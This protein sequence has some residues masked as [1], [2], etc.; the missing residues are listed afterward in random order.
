MSQITEKVKAYLSAYDEIEQEM[1]ELTEEQ[2]RWKAAPGSWSVT[3]VLTHLADHSIVVSFRIRE[4]LSGSETRLPAFNQDAWVSGQL[5]NEGDAQDILAAARAFVYYNSLL[6]KRLPETEWV[7]TAINFKGE[8][9][10][11]SA[12]ITAFVAHVNGHLGQIRRIKAVE[13]AA[14]NIIQE[15]R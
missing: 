11:L 12:I 14:R 9:V 3:E 15:G 2:L 1:K 13:S 6:F 4:L 7:R 10:S 8:S 5:G